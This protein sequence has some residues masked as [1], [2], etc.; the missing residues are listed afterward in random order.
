MEKF[1]IMM[2]ICGTVWFIYFFM[3]YLAQKWLGKS[4][5]T[6]LF[7]VPLL[8]MTMMLTSCGSSGD[9]TGE[10]WILAIVCL[11]AWL[12]GGRG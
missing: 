9:N 8:L 12:K 2:A 5:R 11:L 10:N 4:E 3:L 7:I 6:Q 1:L